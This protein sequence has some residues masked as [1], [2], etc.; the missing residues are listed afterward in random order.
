[1]EKLGI[2]TASVPD[3]FMNAVINFFFFFFRESGKYMMIMI[4]VTVMILLI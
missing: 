2:L 1:M 4:K 3:G